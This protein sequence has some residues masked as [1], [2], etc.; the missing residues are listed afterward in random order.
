M[1]LFEK[2]DYRRVNKR[3]FEHLIKAGALDF[4]GISR[5]SLLA[6]LAGVCGAGAK[7]QADAASGQGSL[8]GNMGGASSALRFRFPEVEAGRCL[9]ALFRR[10]HPGWLPLAPHHLQTIRLEGLA[11]QRCRYLPRPEPGHLVDVTVLRV[12]P[13]A[14][15]LSRPPKTWVQ[16][17]PE[18]H[19]T[20]VQT[21]LPEILAHR[22]PTR[23]VFDGGFR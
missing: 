22:L 5:A 16:G 14:V 9:C 11:A 4:A 6:G 7:F 8:F 3:V 20:S 23:G 18:T 12:T 21:S 17:I 19:F 2:V 13:D 15:S 1:D 10:F